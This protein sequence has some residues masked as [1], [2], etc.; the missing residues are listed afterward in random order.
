MK[1][2]HVVARARGDIA[3]AVGECSPQI[4]IGLRQSCVLRRT[5]ARR[6]ELVPG[7]QPLVI[8]ELDMRAAKRG[9]GAELEIR[10][11][12]VRLAPLVASESSE[13]ELR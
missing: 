7:G 8:E 13:E 12:V 10:F 4:G 1:R 3:I 6:P 9:V 11:N 2:R 5:R